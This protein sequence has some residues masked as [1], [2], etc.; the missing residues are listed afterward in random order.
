MTG[1]TS[2]G[3]AIPTPAARPIGGTWSE[4]D[5]GGA[6]AK[7]DAHAALA[8]AHARARHARGGMRHA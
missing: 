2:A 4:P 5:A 1:P 3:A 7:L 8:E 6:G